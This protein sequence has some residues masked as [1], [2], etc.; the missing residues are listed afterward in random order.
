MKRFVAALFFLFLCL[1][2]AGAQITVKV[3]DS[4]TGENL[5]HADIQM[6]KTENIVTNAQGYFTLPDAI[7][8]DAVVTASFMG[9][10][11]LSVTVAQLIKNDFTMALHPGY[12]Q[13]EEVAVAAF[14]KNPDSI[15]A[16][17]IKNLPENYKS[18][19]E[20]VKN[21]LFFRESS[22]FMPSKLSLYMTQST[23]VSKQGLKEVNKQLQDFTSGLVRNPPAE[24]TDILCNY[25][26][27][28]KKINGKVINHPKFEVVKAVKLK[29]KNKAVTIDEMQKKVE[30]MLYAHI[31]TT[32]YYRLKSGLFGSRD[33]ISFRKNTNGKGMKVKK[34]RRVDAAKANIM[35]FKYENSVQYTRNFDFLENT[36]WYEYSYEGMTTSADGEPVCILR[37]KPKKRKGKYEGTLFI[38]KNDFAILRADYKLAEGKKAGG[39]NLK[40]LLGVKQSE[41]VRQGT[42]IY[43]K[44]D[45]G[46]YYLQYAL[47]ETGDYYYINRPLKLIE[48]T[49]D[50][51]EKVAFDLKVETNI[52]NVHEYLNI[53][54]ENVA[55]TEIEQLKE[56][57]FDFDYPESYNASIWKEYTII[58]PLE[59]MKRFSTGN[60]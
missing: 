49:D 40:F 58:E 4:A 33:T 32:K 9:Y 36:A 21:V 22:S 30:E 23:G 27:Y 34:K 56:E 19:D 13:L 17:V 39:V 20:N 47:N 59:E 41:N 26:S 52:T 25:Y 12:F 16:S 57:E 28:S 5:P 15:I 6:N 45:S 8:D 3:I 10:K 50:D 31:D 37:F 42:L 2:H 11:S 29:D 60:K 46:G 7:G 18:T 35:N 48:L 14:N 43:K 53:E 54:R 38:S 44:K 51:R 24:Y 55:G 1:Y